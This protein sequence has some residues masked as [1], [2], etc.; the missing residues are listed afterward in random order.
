MTLSEYF[1]KYGFLDVKNNQIVLLENHFDGLYQLERS[2]NKTT[3]I[4]GPRQSGKSTFILNF[5]L[6]LLVTKKDLTIVFYSKNQMTKVL[7][8][9]LFFIASNYKKLGIDDFQKTNVNSTFFLKTNSKIIFSK[10]IKGINP[11]HFVIDNLESELNDEFA[12]INVINKEGVFGLK[13]NDKLDFET[14]LSCS[15][16]IQTILN[17]SNVNVLYNHFSISPESHKLTAILKQEA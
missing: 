2:E 11:T 14:I 5:L 12:K 6:Y 9:N 10:N 13:V 17:T 7:K 16:G 4:S 15:G 8:E 1:D 3:C